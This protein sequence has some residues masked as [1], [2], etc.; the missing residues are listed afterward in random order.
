MRGRG[1]EI[2]QILRVRGVGWPWGYLIVFQATWFG[3]VMSAAAGRAGW[4][5]GFGATFAAVHLALARRPALELARL[6]AAGILGF[7]VEAVLLGVGAIEFGAG[8]TSVPIWMVG[9]WVGF[10]ALLPVSIGWLRGRYVASALFGLVGGPLS[11]WGGMRLGALE[12]GELG[13]GAS[14]FAIGLAWGVA[15]PILVASIEAYRWVRRRTGERNETEVEASLRH[16][17]SG[18]RHA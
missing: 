16:S 4:S 6:A 13:L 9:L 15:S 7:G 12:P 1:V 2:P 18:E 17:T 10:A 14:L 8:V 3:I 11:Y 5:V